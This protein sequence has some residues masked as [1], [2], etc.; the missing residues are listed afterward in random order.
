MKKTYI[1]LFWLVASVLLLWL[2]GFVAFFLYISTIKPAP[3]SNKSDVVIV[4]T[5]AP[6]RVSA[7][8]N[9]LKAKAAQQMFISGVHA[10]AAL[11]SIIG[12]D[13]AN[14]SNEIILGKGA[15]TT[16]QNGQ[17]AGKW[18][19]EQEKPIQS[20]RLVTSGYHMPRARMELCANIPNGVKIIIHPV[21]D[22]RFAKMNKALIK[23]VLSEYH[24]CIL[25]WIQIKF[26]S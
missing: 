14:L 8:L 13:N 22:K 1:V 3:L 23:L 16:Q 26:T 9:I 5:G 7:G 17:E 10:D 11:I 18:I 21:P 19:S 25:R 6:G 15:K 12:K 20:V 4:F 2:V 24:K